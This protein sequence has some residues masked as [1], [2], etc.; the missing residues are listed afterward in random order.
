MLHGPHLIGRHEVQKTLS[1][2]L[3]PL[4][5]TRTLYSL[6]TS[7]WFNSPASVPAVHPPRRQA[8]EHPHHQTPSHQTLWLWVRQDSQWVFNKTAA[9]YVTPPPAGICCPCMSCRGA[10]MWW[11]SLAGFRWAAQK[12]LGSWCVDAKADFNQSLKICS[13]KSARVCREISEFQR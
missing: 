5:L 10:L 3:F 11:V 12:A 13:H 7:R 1:L 9:L 2:F 4:S 8:G 6:N